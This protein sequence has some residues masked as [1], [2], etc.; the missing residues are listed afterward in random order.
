[1]NLSQRVVNFDPNDKN[2]PNFT[3]LVDFSQCQE[4][5]R[6]QGFLRTLSNILNCLSETRHMVMHTLKTFLQVR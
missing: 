6:H 1:M 5:P 2:T 3:R 4:K